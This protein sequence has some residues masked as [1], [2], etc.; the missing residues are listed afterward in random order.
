MWAAVRPGGVVVVE[1]ADF[2]GSFCYPPN[3]AFDFWVTAYQ[4]ALRS[5]AA[6]R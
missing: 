5:A 2:E 1:D 6:T 4:Q 3:A